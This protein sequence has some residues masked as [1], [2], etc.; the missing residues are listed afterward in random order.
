MNPLGITDPVGLRVLG[1]PI[2]PLG[3]TDPVGQGRRSKPGE[4][5]THWVKKGAIE[6]CGDNW[7]FRAGEAK[8]R[9]LFKKHLFSGILKTYPPD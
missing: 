5:V 3:I 1:V 8:D 2:D 4:K 6:G 9:L 7:S